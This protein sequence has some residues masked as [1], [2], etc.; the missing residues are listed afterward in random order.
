M[1]NI[2]NPI[3]AAVIKQ[4]QNGD[5]IR[6]V[7]KK[8]GFAYSAVYRWV[9]ELAKCYIFEIKD[10]GNKKRIYAKHSDLYNQFASLIKSLNEANQDREFWAFIK[11]TNLKVRFT[12]GTA[13]SLWTH[14]SYITGDFF[15]K[16]YILEV[17]AKESDKLKDELD[18]HGIEYTEGEK[19]DV[20][21][22]VF[23]STRSDFHVEK[24]EGIPVMPLMELV[25]WCKNLDLDAALEHLN[26]LY[27]LGL[28]QKYSE[29]HTN[30]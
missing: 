1:M 11:K 3:T 20:K 21:P 2:I 16:I 6:E 27:N 4:A 15:D 9:I 22:L 29:V 12:D 25:E 7:A 10:E 5:T 24:L 8:T 13:I 18:K 14:G 19:K 17:A 23:L 30:V 26:D 28:K